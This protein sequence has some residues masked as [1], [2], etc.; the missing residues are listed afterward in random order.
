M[1][2][3]Y[4]K[5]VLLQLLIIFV[6]IN[7]YADDYYAGTEGL[8]GEELKSALHDIIDG[9]IEFSYNALRDS[10]LPN[11]DEDPNNPNNVILLYTGISIPKSEF[12]GM[13]NEWNREHVWAKSHGDFGVSPPAGTDAHHIRSSNVWVN[14]CRGNKDFDNGGSPVYYIDI[15]NNW[16][17]AGWSDDDSWE[18]RDEV[19]G[20][21]A[22]MIFYMVVRYEGDNGEIDLE[23]VDYIPSSPNSEPYHAKLSSLLQWHIQ[24]SVDFWEQTRNNKI[25]ENWQHNRN[26]FIDHP[27]FAELIWD[28]AAVYDD[29]NNKEYN[30]ISFPNPFKTS[31]TISFSATDLYKLQQIKIYNIKGQLVKEFKIQSPIKLGIKLKIHEVE[32]DGTDLE[33]NKLQNGI[34]LYQLGTGNNKSE[35]KKMILLK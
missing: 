28:G 24:D 25:Y 1:I 9:H 10:I 22:R 14:S 18:P 12:G 26:P 20:D 7:I 33:G 19:K 31:V 2:M 30:L 17:L 13:V 21:V 23:M 16:H 6:S 15:Y 4:F 3:K 11:T 5:L 34:Y 27:E 8:T 29:I 35:V 32:W